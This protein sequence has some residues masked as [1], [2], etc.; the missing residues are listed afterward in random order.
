MLGVFLLVDFPLLLAG[1]NKDVSGALGIV[2]AFSVMPPIITRA[3]EDANRSRGKFLDFMWTAAAMP[4]FKAQV[5][6]WT[7]S[8]ASWW[9]E[10]GATPG[11]FAGNYLVSVASAVWFTVR[12]YRMFRRLRRCPVESRAALFLGEPERDLNHLLGTGVLCCNLESFESR[13]GSDDIVNEKHCLI[14][15]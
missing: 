14:A 7:L 5:S 1:T 4:A 2:A 15:K 13:T 12:K 10:Y 11:T 3:T 8:L 9:S 6:F